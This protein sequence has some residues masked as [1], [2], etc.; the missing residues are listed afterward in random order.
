MAKRYIVKNERGEQVAL[1]ETLFQ[2]ALHCVRNGVA[3]WTVVDANNK[4]CFART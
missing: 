1:I 3:G 2:A 4:I